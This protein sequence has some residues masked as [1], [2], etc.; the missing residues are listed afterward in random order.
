[1]AEEIADV[2]PKTMLPVMETLN[3]GFLVYLF[4]GRGMAE[5]MDVPEFFEEEHGIVHAIQT[6]LQR[7]D[8]TGIQMDSGFLA[9]R[10]GAVGADGEIRLGGVGNG[11]RQEEP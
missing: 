4:F 1:M 8:V 5:A 10:K 7:L 6:E 2:Q 11:R 3:P 9:G